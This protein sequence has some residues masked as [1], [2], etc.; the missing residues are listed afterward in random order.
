MNKFETLASEEL[1]TVIGGRNGWKENVAE[2]GGTATA[3]FAIG[4]AI[5]GG[6]T[7]AASGV[8]FCKPA[9]PWVMAGCGLI[10]AAIGGYIGYR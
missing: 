10:G 5:A 8:K 2:V 6:L 9:G 4:S 1:S 3:G 7:G